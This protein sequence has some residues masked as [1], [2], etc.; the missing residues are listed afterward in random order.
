LNSTLELKK[1]NRIFYEAGNLAGVSFTKRGCRILKDFNEFIKNLQETF[2]D[3]G[4]GILRVEEAD[5]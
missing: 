4:I 3:L 2:R 5:Y 1:Q